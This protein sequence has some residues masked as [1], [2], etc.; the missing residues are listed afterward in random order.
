MNS[1]EEAFW[2]ACSPDLSSL[3][4]FLWN[5]LKNRINVEALA[6]IEELVQKIK[7]EIKTISP[8]I[9]EKVF[10]CIYVPMYIH[11]CVCVCFSVSC[12]L[13]IYHGVII[14]IFFFKLS[15]RNCVLTES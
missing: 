3:D 8:A 2:P 12:M 10:S 1:S 9:C 7:A 11:V 13:C 4:F 6:T 14:I 15:N 5:F